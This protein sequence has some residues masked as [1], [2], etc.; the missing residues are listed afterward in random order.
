MST[1]D[2][3]IKLQRYYEINLSH[4][5]WS[6]WAS[7]GS[8]IVG[9]VALLAGVVMLFTQHASNHGVIVTIAGVIS[10]FISATF[11][12]LYN[13]NMKQLNLFY[14]K[15]IKFQDTYLAI[16]LMNKLPENERPEMT[17]L[18]ISNLITRNEPKTQM[19]PEL[20]RAY[21]ETMQKNKRQPIVQ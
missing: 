16:D 7:L 20:V 6:F 2:E 12:F 13:K 21:G 17:T 8:V 4:A 1:P 18:L 3:F 10:E 19:S 9:L 5:T 14:E 15:L 11:F